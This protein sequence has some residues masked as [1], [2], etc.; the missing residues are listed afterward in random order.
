MGVALE[1]CFLTSTPG[2]EVHARKEMI[3][4]SAYD[5]LKYIDDFYNDSK[6]IEFLRDSGIS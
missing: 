2:M 6:F 3:K 1:F 4:Q 5:I